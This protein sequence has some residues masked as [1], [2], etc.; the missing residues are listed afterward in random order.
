MQILV[1]SN[2]VTS[3]PIKV[4]LTVAN[5]FQEVA[6]GGDGNDVIKASAGDDVLKGGVGD[7]TLYGSLGAD[8]LT[9]DAGRDVFV[10]DTQPDSTN[11]DNIID[12]DANDDMIYLDSAVFDAL[13]PGDLSPNSFIQGGKATTFDQH[14]IYNPFTGALMYDADGKGFQASVTIAFLSVDGLSAANF[15]VI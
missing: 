15:H 5:L 14:I 3:G 6:V 12:F 8:E 13:S 1:T 7:D 11:I 2:G 9:G 4:I 10:F